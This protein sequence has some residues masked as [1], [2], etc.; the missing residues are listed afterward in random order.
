MANY[1]AELQALTEE[2]QRTEDALIA[3]GFSAEHWKLIKAYIGSAVT[4]SVYAA[5]HT[6]GQ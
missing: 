6:K 3:S 1:E 4:V 2:L 5:S